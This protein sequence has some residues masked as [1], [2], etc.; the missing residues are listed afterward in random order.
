MWVVY[1]MVFVCVLFS[2]ANSSSGELMEF[3][4]WQIYASCLLALVRQAD[5][6]RKQQVL[7][8]QP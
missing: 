1:I 5:V 8:L 6:V 7:K 2:A 3:V 4:G